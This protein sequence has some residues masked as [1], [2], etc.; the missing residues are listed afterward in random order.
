MITR[1]MESVL[2][3]L[4]LIRSLEWSLI[5]VRNTDFTLLCGFAI[6]TSPPVAEVCL[7][8]HAA[9]LLLNRSAD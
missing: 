3:G 7:Y 2:L 5:L 8:W 6:K 9:R 4:M 1:I